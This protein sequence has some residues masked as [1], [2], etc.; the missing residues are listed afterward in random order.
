MGEIPH[1]SNNYGRC[2]FLEHHAS[3]RFETKMFGQIASPKMT[4]TQEALTRAVP[5]DRGGYHGSTQAQAGTR[6]SRSPPQRAAVNL[7]AAGI[8]VGAEA[9]YVAVPPS[10]DPQPVR[11][12][13]A[14]TVA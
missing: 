6:Q 11:C 9:H 8:D 12:F 5:G 1:V 14:Y 10:D 2:S 7:H 4:M 3:Q 13:G